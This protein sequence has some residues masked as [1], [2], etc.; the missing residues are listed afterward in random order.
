MNEQ[1]NEALLAL[2]NK[3]NGPLWDFLVIF[4]VAV[5]IFYTVITGAVQLRLF[6][7]SLKVMK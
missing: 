6:A 7:H 3:L 5:G 2:V 4:L 1:L